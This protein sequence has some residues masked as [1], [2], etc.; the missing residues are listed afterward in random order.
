MVNQRHDVIVVGAGPAGSRA[1][2]DLARAGFCVALLEE[3]RQIGVPCHC[4]GL[5]T[6]RTLAIAQ[7][8]DDIVL[9]TIRG[10]VIHLSS[11]KRYHLGGDRVHAYV[12]DRVA[13]DQRLVEQAVDAG[14]DLLMQTRFLRYRL[15]G[16]AGGRSGA[17]VA[18]VVR[19]G[20]ETELHARLLIGA[21]GARSK[22]AEQVRGSRAERVVAGL[23]GFARYNANPRLDHVELFLDNHAAPGW[24]GWS[25]PLETGV[26]RVGTGSANGIKPI[27]SF[28]RLR[29]RFRDSFGQAEVDSHTGGTIAIWEPTRM[30]ADRVMLV[31]DAARQVKP[32][33][34][35][36][37]HAALHA[38]GLAAETAIE[39]LG[40]SDLSARSLGRY[41]QRWH[42]S[43]GREMRRGY[44]LRRVFTKLTESRLDTLVGALESEPLKAEVEAVGDIDFPSR[45]AWAVARRNPALALRLW[46]PPRFPGVWLTRDRAPAER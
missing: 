25:I 42:A 30:V 33:S 1:A 35:G 36:G 11:G 31:G 16:P 14:A 19:E 4:S 15:S 20:V 10:A 44:D 41:A 6:P 22:V 26:A 2:R 40:E 23:G 21:D 8:G 5:V 28:A 32:T 9:N 12:I 27:E 34:G 46:S 37:I 7:A 17:V 24:F 43:L 39:A 18:T 38:A 45:V 3:H 13:L 29:D